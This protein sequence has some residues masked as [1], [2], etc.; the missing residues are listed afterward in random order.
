MI[1][2][3]EK[4]NDGNNHYFK[5]VK[6]LDQDLE[7]YISELMYDEMP[8]L[9]TYQSTLGVPHPQTGDYLIYKDGEINFFSNTRDFEN[10]FFSRTVDLKSLLGKKLIQEVSYKIFDL[11]M[12]LS[13]KIEA[14]YMDIADLEMGLDIANC[15]RDYI[16]INKL[17]NDLQDLQKELGDLKK[18]YNVKILGGIKVD[19]K[20]N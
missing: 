17:K 16:N 15:N 6:D 3:F 5:I 20:I 1:N 14:I 9:G 13:S 7:P 4:L 19:E 2:K 12:K 8:G 11:D 18:E 10:V